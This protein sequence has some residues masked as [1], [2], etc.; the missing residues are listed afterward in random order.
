MRIAAFIGLPEIALPSTTPLGRLH[1]IPGVVDARKHWV[2]R[3]NSQRYRS[4]ATHAFAYE[5]PTISE[6][7]KLKC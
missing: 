5:G 3:T 6:T 2:A 4:S 7:S 1:S